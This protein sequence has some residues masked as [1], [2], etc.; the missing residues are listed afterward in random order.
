MTGLGADPTL[1]DELL[2]LALVDQDGTPCITR[3]CDRTTVAPGVTPKPSTAS[4]GPAWRT[5]QLSTSGPHSLR[6]R[7]PTSTKSPSTTRHLA[8]CSYRSRHGC[9]SRPRLGAPCVRCHLASMARRRRLLSRRVVRERAVP[10]KVL[11]DAYGAR[12]PLPASN[13]GDIR[14]TSSRLR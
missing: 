6:R 9:W 8:C 14:M 4:D 5:P 1:V 2:E 11:R 12:A 13:R 3:W 7:S 10:V